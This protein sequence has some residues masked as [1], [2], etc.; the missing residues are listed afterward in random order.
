[1]IAIKAHFDGKNI[2]PDEP[3]DVP[4]DT[5][6]NVLIDVAKPKRKRALG[7]AKGMAK[8]LPE[9]FDPLPPEL[10]AAF[11]GEAP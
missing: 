1:M 4:E 8:I 9:F 11:N 7:L 3:L 10:L 5:P 2:V 6:L